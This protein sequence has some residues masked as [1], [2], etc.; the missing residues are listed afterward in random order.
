MAE[1]IR[2]IN[3][4][5]LGLDRTLIFTTEKTLNQIPGGTLYINPTNGNVKYR[6]SGREDW[7]RFTP[8][9]LLDNKSITAKHIANSTITNAQIADNTIQN[10]NLMDLTISSGK[11][12]DNAISRQ[13]IQNNAINA[14][15]IENLT[16]VNDKIAE[17]TIQASKLAE[18]AVNDFV[19]APDSVK[20]HHI[21]NNAVTR[22]KIANRAIDGSKIEDQSVNTN[23]Y[24]PSSVTKE[25]LGVGCVINEKLAAN[26]VATVNIQNG[27][28]TTDKIANNGVTGE[29][30][31]NGVITTDKLAAAS[32]TAEKLGNN[33]VG[34]QHIVDAA[35]TRN[36][37]EPN[38]RNDIQNAIKLI[39]GTAHV[40]GH[41]TIANNLT[42][43]GTINASKVYSAVYNDLAEGYVPGESLSA[44]DIVEL[45]EDGKVYRVAGHGG[46]PCIVGVVSDCYAACYGATEEELQKGKKVAVGLIGRVPVKVSGPV[47]IGQNIGVNTK[48]FKGIGQATSLFNPIKIGKALEAKTDDSIG[49]VLCLIFPN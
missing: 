48:G 19:L 9:N 5:V 45:K 8:S 23:H 4:L 1:G 25:I 10:K 17:R 43:T 20:E 42:V 16:I 41:M 3:E 39:S 14:A 31:Q 28:I 32:V 15:K 34:T 44:G 7:S 37:L 22:N 38:V 26:S 6:Q 36:K 33:A 13:K 12:A 29:K 49:E 46:T 21:S 35:V 11:I 40:A 2:K 24:F 47:K 30:I 18:G 27:A